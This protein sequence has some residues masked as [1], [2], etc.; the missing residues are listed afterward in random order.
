V[1]SWPRSVER[2]DGL[3]DATGLDEHEVAQFVGANAATLY[4][5]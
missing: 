2:I 1:S 4:R 3:V 5:L